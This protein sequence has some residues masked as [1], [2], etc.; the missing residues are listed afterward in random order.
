MRH[1]LF[2]VKMNMEM[3]V[4]QHHHS[5]CKKKYFSTFLNH[6]N[7]IATKNLVSKN[8][9]W[10]PHLLLNNQITRMANQ[11]QHLNPL[12]QLHFRKKLKNPNH[13]PPSH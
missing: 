8:Q 13:L 9:P 7:L 3:L 5:Q 1:K 6:L 2:K 12:L 11:R 10:D 4:A